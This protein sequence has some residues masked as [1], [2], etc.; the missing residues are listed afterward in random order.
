[1]ACEPVLLPESAPEPPGE[2]EPAAP[3]LVVSFAKRGLTRTNRFELNG[4][5]RCT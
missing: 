3:L 5:T 4:I 2:P 1:M